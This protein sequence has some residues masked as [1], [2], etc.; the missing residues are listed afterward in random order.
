MKNCNISDEKLE[1]LSKIYN[2]AHIEISENV[3]YL[4]KDAQAYI[5]DEYDEYLGSVELSHYEELGYENVVNYSPLNY[6]DYIDALDLTWM[7]PDASFCFEGNKHNKSIKQIS[8]NIVNL[9]FSYLS[10]YIS[11]DNFHDVELIV[12]NSN[13]NIVRQAQYLK[14]FLQDNST[15]LKS[16]KF[17][18]YNYVTAM[19][20]N[21]IVAK[22][23]LTNNA[24]LTL[25]R[26][27]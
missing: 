24:K 22:F 8:V 21:N 10:D 26:K 7:E 12:H 18:G 16:I 6:A 2:N 11:E 17:V 1:H 4:L 3:V 20:L 14:A 13:L 5:I 19:I 9:K 23:N 15:Y 25:S 27:K